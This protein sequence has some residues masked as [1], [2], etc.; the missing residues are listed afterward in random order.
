MAEADNVNTYNSLLAIDVRRKE[1][2]KQL[3]ECE[4][5]IKEQW[6]KLTAR[7]ES[8]PKSKTQ[9]LIEF[10]TNSVGLID[11]A[12]LGY[13]LYRRFSQLKRK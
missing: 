13:K 8:A 5:N 4:M 7:E 12:I 1:L 9:R 2:Q 10:A 11:G 6:T 3:D